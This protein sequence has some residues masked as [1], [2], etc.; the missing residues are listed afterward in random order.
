[1]YFGAQGTNHSI[2]LADE[3]FENVAKFEQWGTTWHVKI[4]CM[5]T[6]KGDEF[7]GMFAF[8]HSE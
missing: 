5:K 4:V 7:Q 2:K 1:M 6:L 3:F 8:S